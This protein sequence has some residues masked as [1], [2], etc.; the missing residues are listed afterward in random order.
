MDGVPWV[1]RITLK[2]GTVMVE[3]IQNYALLERMES[4]Y[5]TE[6]HNLS[7]AWIEGDY[8]SVLRK[9]TGGSGAMAETILDKAITEQAAG[10]A[11]TKPL[12]SGVIGKNQQFYVPVGMLNASGSQAIQLEIFLA[13]NDQVVTRNTGITASP[14][15]ELSEVALNIEVVGASRKGVESVQLRHSFGWVCEVAVQDHSLLPAACAFRPNTHRYEHRGE[16]ERRREG[17]GGY[18]T[19]EQGQSVHDC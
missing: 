14:G 13:S 1:D 7:R 3:D 2:C 4:L 11:Y 5:E 16:F 8:S 12:L 15:Y 19:P 6:D 9:Y 18:A 17:H 10:R